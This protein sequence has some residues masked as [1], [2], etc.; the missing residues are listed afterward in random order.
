LCSTAYSLQN[1]LCVSNCSTGSVSI[2]DAVS[3]PSSNNTAYVC[4]ACVLIFQYCSSCLPS[5]CNLCQTGYIMNYDRTCVAIC[6]SGYINVSSLCV[7]CSPECKACVN[8][9]NNCTGCS[10]GYLLYKNAS[11]NISQCLSGCIAG[12]YTFNG[13]CLTC[14]SPCQTC[15]NA[16]T[17]CLSC[18]TQFYSLIDNGLAC[19]SACPANSYVYNNNCVYCSSGCSLCDANGCL[20]CSP[21]YY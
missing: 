18:T 4:K 11:S 9:Q 2:L 7:A 12:T 5:S 8:L 14:L 6:P 13:A 19:V 3:L 15:V 17:S 16:S 21:L 1:S 10:Q 20:A